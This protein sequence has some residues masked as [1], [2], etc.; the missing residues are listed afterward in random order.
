V[1]KVEAEV[2]D[3]NVS[4]S[5][6]WRGVAKCVQALRMISTKLLHHTKTEREVGI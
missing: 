3:H 6:F 5:G 4:A 2:R 1:G